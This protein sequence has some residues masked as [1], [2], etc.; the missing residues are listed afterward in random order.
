VVLSD[1]ARPDILAAAQM[2]A[3]LNPDAV[4]WIRSTYPLGTRCPI[5]GLRHIAALEGRPIIGTDIVTDL[6][7]IGTPREAIDALAHLRM[8][9][10]VSDLWS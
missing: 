2:F 10:F 1:R 8:V 5:D 3:R 9:G 7:T 6:V 4:R